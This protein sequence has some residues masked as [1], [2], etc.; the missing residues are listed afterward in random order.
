MRCSDISFTRVASG[1]FARSV[2]QLVSCFLFSSL[3]PLFLF[4]PDPLYL[5]EIVITMKMHD[6]YGK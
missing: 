3:F 2:G 5:R 1:S 6:V 4:N